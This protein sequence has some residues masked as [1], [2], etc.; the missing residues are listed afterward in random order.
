[1]IDDLII[2]ANSPAVLQNSI[3]LLYKYCSR[4]QL[5]LNVLKTE[6][7]LFGKYPANVGHI[8]IFN[9]NDIDVT[10]EYK[11]LGYLF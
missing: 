11:Y 9:G 6:I 7:M 8:F 3:D 10:T 5:I 1:M 4:W 2:V